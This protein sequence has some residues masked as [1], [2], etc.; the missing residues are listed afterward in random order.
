VV[1]KIL[2]VVL[3]LALYA[4]YAA[5]T[6]FRRRIPVRQV[7][8]AQTSLLL[9]LYLLATAGL[10]VFWVAR[11]Q[12]PVF[13]LHY[14][15]GYATLLLVAVHLTLNLPLAWRH[16][17]RRSRPTPRAGPRAVAARRS[18]T[19]WLVIAA[20]LVG[21]FLLG[22]R[23]GRATL[24]LTWSAPGE[25]GQALGPVSAIV[26]YHEYSSQSRGEVFARAPSVDWGAELPDYKPYPEAERVALPSPR[27]PAGERPLGEALRGP[28]VATGEGP[29]PT[30]DAAALSSVLYHTAGAIRLANGAIERPSPSSG[31]LFPTEI[32]VVARQVAGVAPG[33][34]HFDP[35]HHRLDR[36]ARR[37]PSPAELGAPHEA[38]ALSRAPATLLL[39]ARFHRT[40]HKYGD[41]AYRYAALDVGHLMANLQVAA[42]EAGAAARFVGRFDEA[43][44]AATLGIDGVQEG[45]MA[46]ASIEPAAWASAGAPPV[47]F[48]YPT[49]PAQP[50]KAIGVTGMVHLATSLRA[51]AT[52][53]GA[54]TSDAGSP[55]P[56]ILLP[57]ARPAPGLALHTIIERRSKRRFTDE[58]VALV[59]LA[60]LLDDAQQ[61]PL[62]SPAV[63]TYL[64]VNRVTDLQPGI[65]RHLPARRGLQLVRPG[66]LAKEAYSAGLSQ[67]VVGDAAVVIVWTA[68]RNEVLNAQGA[69]GYR[70]VLLEAG[71]T[72]ERIMLSVTARGL[73]GC[74]V[75]A[76]YDDEAARLIGV[77]GQQQWVLHFAAIGRVAP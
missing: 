7:F 16:L 76:F 19:T 10:G 27:P 73:G 42:A 13:D 47:T 56:P 63:Q 50:D 3:P 8:N 9:M 75:G 11:Q 41:R 6:A 40:G 66:D 74:P 4:A 12:L 72:G 59:D 60:S 34:Y 37:L 35:E 68:D 61:P 38:A 31:A 45:V 53:A 51:P 70:H 22:M 1:P 30:F 23:H 58:P 55:R 20:A 57:A 15:F 52:P 71:V 48:R 5:A 21:A 17:T 33:L 14:V 24:A 2:W 32:Y 18:V 36:L 44:S 54:A 77:D 67:D 25:G 26:Q 29:T 46:L 28:S 69:R 49:P 64:V 43:V 65:Y 39:T 62:L